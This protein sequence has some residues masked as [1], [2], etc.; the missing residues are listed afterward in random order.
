[1]SDFEPIVLDNGSG[2]FKAGFAG[3]V[4]PF[5]VFPAVVGRIMNNYTK[6]IFVGNEIQRKR[7]LTFLNYPIQRGQISNWSDIEI[8]WNHA[9]NL[10]NA[11]P[12]DHSVLL[13]ESPN[14]PEIHRELV[15]E[16]MF[17]DFN[18][19]RLYLAIQALLALYSSGRTT[20]IVLDSGDHVTHTVPIHDGNPIS[21]A[22]LKF[23]LGGRDLNDYLGKILADR[24]YYFSTASEKDIVR[25]IKEKLCYLTLDFEGEL[26]K[27]AK[28]KDSYEKTYELPDGQSVFLD[29]ERFRCPEVLFQPIALG[30]DVFGIHEEIYHSIMK[31]DANIRKDVYEN[32]VLSG[33]NTM[34][35][36]LPERLDKELKDLTKNEV[37]INIVAPVNRFNSVWN[38]G[39]ILASLSTFER[40]CISRAEYR[41]YGSSIVHRKCF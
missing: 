7:G 9:Y 20:G 11:S 19:P 41:E 16:L 21:H 12:L 5:A 8:I 38:G 15:T 33:G 23:D 24:G 25:D 3:Y 2:I 26:A 10:L 18:V 40:M 13:T 30:L 4:E 27:A 29:S 17:E 32:I 36:G 6:A 31:V 22:I 14:S 28:S 35:Q 34:F 37:N 1:M 39:S